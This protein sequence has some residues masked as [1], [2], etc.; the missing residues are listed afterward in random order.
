MSI[1]LEHCD[2]NNLNNEKSALTKKEL[3]NFFCTIVNGK[4]R[5]KRNHKYYY[6][7]QMHL[8]ICEKSFCDFIV[9]TEWN[10]CGKNKI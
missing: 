2:P 6:Q 1:H 5:L 3:N 9:V 10:V 4:L 8:G 7:V